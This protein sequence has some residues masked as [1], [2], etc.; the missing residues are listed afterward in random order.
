M[1][2]GGGKGY[3][4]STAMACGRRGSEEGRRGRLGAVAC[5]ITAKE[6]GQYRPIQKY[7]PDSGPRY[8]ASVD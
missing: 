4:T 7:R 3:Q 6:E 1:K 5:G 8:A 2:G